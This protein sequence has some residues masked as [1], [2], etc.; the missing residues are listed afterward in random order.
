MTYVSDDSAGAYEPVTGVW[1]IGDLADGAV[2]T[3]NITAL[4]DIGARVLPQPVTNTTTAATS[5]QV[6][7]DTLTDDLS[8]DVFITAITPD[9]IRLVKTTGRERAAPGEIV[10]YSVELRSMTP[11]AVNDVQV[12]DTPARGFK[13]VSGTTQVDGVVVDDPSRGLPL[14]FDIGTVPGL[15]DTNGNGVADPGETGYRILTYRMV[16]GSGVAPGVWTNSAVAISTCDDC[17]VS[18]TATADIEIIEDTLFDLGTIIGKVFYDADSDGWQGAGEAGIAAAMVALDDGTY[19]LTDQF[20]RYHFPAVKPGQRLVKINLNSLAGRAIATNDKTQILNVTPGLLAKANFGVI[21]DTVD[22]AIGADGKLGVM[23]DSATTAPPILINGST[24][25]MSLL[26]NGQPAALATADVRLST[27]QLDDVVEL[28]AGKLASPIR[29]T[30][31]ANK[32]VETW[33]LLVSSSQGEVIYTRAGDRQV[34]AVIEWDGIRDNGKLIAGGDVYT[35]QLTLI[36]ADGETLT[37]NRRIFGVNRRNTVSLNLAGGA[38]VTG[39]HELTSKAKTLLKQTAEAI[40]SYPDEVIFIAGHTDSVGTA[41]SNLALAER[42]ARSAFNY[43]TST[44]QIPEDRFVVQTYGE[45]RPIADNESAWGRELNRRVEINGDLRKVDMA[46]NYDP[47]RQPP[48]VRI[49][50]REVRVDDNGRFAAELDSNEARDSM[51]VLLATV[52]GGS[53]ETTIPLPTIKVLSPSDT[54]AIPYEEQLAGQWFADSTPPQDAVLTTSLRAQTEPGN[55]VELDGEELHVDES[56]RFE[57]LIKVRPGDNYYGIVARNPMGML[58]IANLRLSVTDTVDGKPAV[59][60]EPIPQLALQLPPSGVPMTN[61][62]LVVPG[63]TVPGNRVYVNDT[64][65]AV[66]AAGNFVLTMALERGDNP[67]TARVVDSN[68]YSGQIEQ[69]INYAGDKMFFMALLDGKFSQIETSGSL[70]AAGTDKRSETVSEGRIAYYLKGHVRGKYL[71]TSAFDSGQQKLGDLFADITARDNERLLTNLDPDT[72]YPVYGD[73]STLVYD[74]QSQSKFYVALES[75]KLS[76]MIG[77]YALNFTDTE[78]A[79]Y[80][81]TLYGASVT[82]LSPADEETGARKTK[83]QAFYANIDQAHVR[84]EMRA[85]G[86]SL[87]YLSQRD[88]IEGSEH[89]SVIVRDQDSGLILER[90]ALQQGLDYTIDY[91]DGRLLTN[92]PLSSVKSDNS[93]IDNNIL[94]GNAVYLQVDYET[95]VDGFEQTA[96]GVRVRQ[97]IGERLSLGVTGIDEDQLGGQY[98]L[99]AVDAEYKLG[100]KSRLVAEFATSEGNNSVAYVSEDGGLTYQPVTQD[101]GSSGDAFKIA[102]E[103]DAGQW[104]GW[105]DRLLINTYF[106]RLDTG[107]SANSVTSEQG[108]EKSGIGASLKISDN[109]SMLARYE[110]Q[111]QLGDGSE[112]TLGTVQWNLKR[113]RWGVAAELEDRSGYSGDATMLAVRVNNRWTDVLSTILEHQQTLSGVANDQS[114]VGVAFKA[115]EKLTLDARATTGTLGDS[116][117]LGAQLEWRGNRFYLAQQFNDQVSSG[118]NNKRLVGV[119]LPFGPDGALYSEY[120]WNELSTGNQQQ[121][122]I[123]ARQ[124]FKTDSGLQLQLSGEHSAQNSSSVHE[125]ERYAISA[126]VSYEN[127]NGI[128][129][130]TRNEYRQDSRSMASEQF[131]STTNLTLPMSDS[132]SVLGKYRFSKS[133]SEAEIERNIDFTEAS[134][135]LA[136]RPV[137]HDR[138]NLLTRYTRLSNTPTVFQLANISGGVSSDIFAVD[139]SYQLTQRI[140][141]VGKQAMRWSEDDNDPLN[142]RSLTSL[143]IQ[144]V[145]WSLPKDFLLGT[146]F[147]RMTQDLANDERN[148]FATEI[149]WEGFD[150]LRIGIGYNFSEVSD[151]EYVEYDFTSKGFFMRLQGKF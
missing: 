52:Q 37:S 67:F 10:T 136:Y 45:S 137:A 55:T 26:V 74:A 63:K 120:H 59:V 141:W 29:F 13:Y 81:R 47:Y 31:D 11:Y 144:R 71:L 115:T 122:M 17:F 109:S 92:G 75:D 100:G 105:D 91:V 147:R 123:G 110:K 70:E 6:D 23:V 143:S 22:A 88:I 86:G 140:E 73:D 50:G 3:L 79:A 101:A 77:N 90:R 62:R 53:I 42:R 104:F 34:P 27:R 58:R 128:R 145:N 15:V 106:K 83:A 46:K 14:V 64:E 127:E 60:V 66:D 95:R 57:S 54:F 124:R 78:L 113:E 38:F 138:L 116:A 36:T 111:T 119:E 9:L 7:P 118:A 112:N 134:I 114:T 68:G 25:A 32:S 135:G 65:V 98:S 146:E 33:E 4:V 99:S 103:I 18:N 1:T 5:D 44:E 24:V 12:T 89:L 94:G 139:W 39:S 125:G 19:A 129:I 117:Q 93:L 151:N 87:Y 40:R 43:L 72:L 21:L 16:A 97:G 61:S 8:E 85:T 51:R 80:Q 150:P 102:A 56:G 132:L 126:D 41:A 2:A 35:Y 142:L 20:G 121:Q 131:I 133:E 82:Y 28:E 148:G 30:T 69:T 107:F 149:M 49:D 48:L 84:D 130:S 96:A 108:S 76:A